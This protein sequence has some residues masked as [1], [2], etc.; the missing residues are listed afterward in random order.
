LTEGVARGS[1][2]ASVGVPGEGFVDQ[3]VQVRPW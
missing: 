3:P 1:C 2:G